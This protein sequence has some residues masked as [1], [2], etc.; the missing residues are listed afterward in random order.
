MLHSENQAVKEEL[1]PHKMSI[2]YDIAKGMKYLHH[3]LE[4]P[5]LHRDLKP[6]NVLITAN[7]RAKLTDFGTIAESVSR[8]TANSSKKKKSGASHFLMAVVDDFDMVG[9][10]AYMGP[11]YILYRGNEPLSQDEALAADVWS[12]G[13]TVWEIMTEELPDLVGF[14]PEEAGRGPIFG[15]YRKVFELGLVLPRRDQVPCWT[16]GEEDS[17]P[18]S[19]PAMHA[20]PSWAR[21]LIDK[22]LKLGWDHRPSFWDVVDD[23]AA[24]QEDSLSSVT[25]PSDIFS[26]SA[27]S[28]TQHQAR[29][30]WSVDASAGRHSDPKARRL[31]D[32]GTHSFSF[33]EARAM[34]DKQP[35]TDYMLYSETSLK[36]DDAHQ[37]LLY[38][39]R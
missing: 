15:A 8:S 26:T 14:Y 11:E 1:F 3:E 25:V 28:P 19:D 32:S 13:V 6:S 31:L 24:L 30:V 10:L 34:A 33:E 5:L 23:L 39:R 22:C 20:M 12:F 37:P 21:I 27:L 35:E 2:V 38:S 17:A 16:L 4:M 29:H 18:S 7:W 9:T 36:G